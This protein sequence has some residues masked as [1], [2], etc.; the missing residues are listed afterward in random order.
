MNHE[1]HSR[2]MLRNRAKE[3]V[4]S[5]SWC[6]KNAGVYLKKLHRA[7]GTSPM[8]YRYV[9]KKGPCWMKKCILSCVPWKIAES[10]VDM[11]QSVTRIPVFA[12]V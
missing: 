8:A 5:L 7:K 2:E 4:D 3:Y 9:R 1:E 12:A 6:Q 11:V 10:I